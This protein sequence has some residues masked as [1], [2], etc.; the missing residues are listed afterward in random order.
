MVS[1]RTEELAVGYG[2]RPLLEKLNLEVE[3]GEILTLIGPNGCG[4]STILKTITRQLK[5]VD[6]RII[7]MGKE[8]DHMSGNEI[9]RTQSM[10]MTQRPTPELM[11]CRE[12]VGTGRYPYVGRLGIL[13]ENDWKIVEKAMEAVSALQV[14]DQSFYEISDG[15]KQRVMLARAICQEP[16]I[17]VLD[18]PTSYLDMKYK[19]DILGNIRR[20]AKERGIAVI[21]SL[22]ELDL[23][24][25]ISDRIACVEEDGS[26]NIGSP[27]ELFQGE[28]IQK[29]YQVDRENFNP[30]TGALF[31]RSEKKPPKV[32]V[33]GGGGAGIPVYYK[34]QREG[35]PFA[36]GILFD[37]D[38]E[39]DA[40]AAC[41]S[42]L[43]CTEAFEPVPGEKI[44]EARAMIDTCEKVICPVKKFG[45]YNQENME[46][47]EYAKSRGKLLQ[48]AYQGGR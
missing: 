13:G 21:M 4:K 16:E 27:E 19:L 14:A 40:A 43:I 46:L 34:L 47:L 41:A 20:L 9:A 18:E 15:Q 22:H 26:L 45:T 11:S 7:F 30:L 31:F 39:M 38:L 10:V 1:L 28:E 36:A 35:V 23:A 33:I 25:K 37:N 48:E 12:V 44:D 42:A 17:L 2:K 24:I 3:A 29:L 8:L 6:G 32:F 5:K